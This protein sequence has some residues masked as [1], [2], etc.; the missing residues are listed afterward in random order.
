MKST[1]ILYHKVS[2]IAIHKK[3]SGLIIQAHSA[4]CL[5]SILEFDSAHYVGVL[6]G[7][8]TLDNEREDAGYFYSYDQAPLMA[9]FDLRI[10]Y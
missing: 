7:Y 10:L 2:Q 6:N 8:L 5:L 4:F 1:Q 3:Q 9:L